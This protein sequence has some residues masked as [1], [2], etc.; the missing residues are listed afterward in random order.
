MKFRCS[1]RFLLNVTPVVTLICA[2]IIGRAFISKSQI[3]RVPS[4][5]A[6]PRVPGWR[7]VA[8]SSFIIHGELNVPIESIRKA[9]GSKIY[10]YETLHVKVNESLKGKPG[11]TTLGINLYTEPQPYYLSPD[12]VLKLNGKSV[13]AF[14]TQVDDIPTPK[15][16]FAGDT[17]DTV[18]LYSQTA[19]IAVR[20][21]VQ[22]QRSIVANFPNL[23]SGK[24][25]KL[26]SR[27]QS[28]IKAMLH[29]QTQ[30]EAIN[31]LVSLGPVAVPSIIRLLDDRRP[32]PNRRIRLRN[33]APN[34]FEESRQ[35]RPE[36]VV[37]ALVAIL[38]QITHEP[39]GRIENGGTEQ[40]RT[41]AVNA[42]R[43]Y[44]HYNLAGAV[45]P[46]LKPEQE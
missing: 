40:E 39:F 45:T 37:D 26:H 17:P 41:K 13:L 38:K 31:T 44:L 12:V 36:V 33:Y 23:K 35:Y 28:I 11:T 7:L 8:Q 5:S 46:E 9:I 14:L 21:E 42:W 4:P 6:Q 25:D 32:L 29:E 30:E 2:S 19:A 27:V 10:R 16:Y 18:R 22:N 34:A 43:V 15:V 3:E 20:Q 24:S 1:P